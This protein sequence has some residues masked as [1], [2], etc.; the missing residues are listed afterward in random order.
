MKRPLAPLLL[1]LALTSTAHTREVRF[2]KITL[3]NHFHAEG[4]HYGDFN[5]DGHLDI[6][7][8]PY[9]YAGPG[10]TQRHLIHP[11]QNHDPEQYSDNFITHALDLNNDGWDDVLICPQP[12]TQAYWYENP[13]NTTE[14]WKK[15]PG[16]NDVGNESQQ[17]APIQKNAPPSLIYNT[18]GHLGYA[19]WTARTNQQTLWTFHP[20]SPKSRRF[21]R[22]THGLG[23][24]DINGDGRTDLVERDG[25]W[26]QPRNPA[27]TPWKMHRYPFAIA[28][29]QMLVLD[30]N[31][32]GLP[33]VVTAWH[34]HTYGLVWHQQHRHPTGAITWTRHEIL[35]IKPDLQSPAL[36]IS[37][38]HALATADINGDGL[39]DLITGKRYWA[40]GPKGD[41]EP[42]APPVLYWF[43]LHRDA[44][45]NATFT[46][47]KIDDNSGVGTQITPVDINKDG[48]TDI[49]VANKKGVFLFLQE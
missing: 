13:R 45:G 24:G 23:H 32:D 34:C 41:R 31:G 39:P 16:P 33:D 7:A 40:H 35:P 20:I 1:L 17:L 12:G 47:R 48:K 3:T 25:W 8:G 37:Q 44:K 27:E 36:R 26:E 5:R 14:P 38:M 22:Y 4:I 6:V 10:F 18:D 28:G 30:I 43:E 49:L 2:K 11:E 21:E 42:D 9:W 29:A 46:P 15:H 19:T